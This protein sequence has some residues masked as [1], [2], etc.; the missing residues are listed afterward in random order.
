MHA[1]QD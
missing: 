1:E